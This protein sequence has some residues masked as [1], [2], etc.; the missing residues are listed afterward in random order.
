M[1]IARK[2]TLEDQMYAAFGNVK[3]LDRGE[4][5]R[6][7]VEAACAVAREYARLD[8]ATRASDSVAAT[9][10]AASPHPSVAETHQLDR[11]AIRGQIWWEAILALEVFRNKEPLDETLKRFKYQLEKEAKISPR[12]GLRMQQAARKR[13]RPFD[14]PAA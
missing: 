7:L 2:P 13:W 10:P 4:T 1:T 14:P 5:D 9:A 11:A 6:P 3:H 12:E 8:A